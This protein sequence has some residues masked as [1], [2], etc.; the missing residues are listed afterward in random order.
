[1]INA[2]GVTVSAFCRFVSG[3]DHLPL[4]KMCLIN[5]LNW[6]AEMQAS[7]KDVWNARFDKDE[8]V[9]GVKPN[10]FLRAQLYRLPPAAHILSLGEGEGRNS[11][12]LAEQGHQ[13]SAVELSTS[14]IVKIQRLAHQRQVH[15]DAIQADLEHHPIEIG[16]WDAIISIFCHLPSRVRRQTMQRVCNGLRPGGLLILEGYTPR[17]LEHGT[18]GPKELDLLLEPDDLRMDLVGLELLH[19]V[20]V[21]RKVEEGVLHTG[22]AAVLQVVAQKIG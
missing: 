8:F 6:G 18:G 22:T 1:M 20:E 10:D 15:V 16:Q 13:V 9:Y 5:G 17:Q 2:N 12:F 21:T 4:S 14:G 19:F 11:V 3:I 7:T